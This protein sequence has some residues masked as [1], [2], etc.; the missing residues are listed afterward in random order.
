MNSLDR[1]STAL[2]CSKT[3]PTEFILTDKE[4]E[5]IQKFI[6]S[7]IT[8]G[9]FSIE[10]LM[11]EFEDCHRGVPKQIQRLIIDECIAK[12]TTEQSEWPPITDCDRLDAL[13]EELMKE[14]IL[15]VQ[16]IQTTRSSCWAKV[17]EE[18]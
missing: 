18:I 10:T 13:E 16:D 11:E 15:F 5:E 14:N 3:L 6:L 2:E 8:K 9:Q 12:A 4:K 7:C 1:S 17:E